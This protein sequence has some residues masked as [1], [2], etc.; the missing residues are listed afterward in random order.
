M[1]RGTSKQRESLWP[2]LLKTPSGSRLRTDVLLVRPM[3]EFLALLLS[4][5]ASLFKST[6][7]S[8]RRTLL[9]LPK[10][11]SCMTSAGS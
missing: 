9:C 11:S 1:D 5:L 3:L 7:R 10:T 2:A 8:K 6:E 4:G